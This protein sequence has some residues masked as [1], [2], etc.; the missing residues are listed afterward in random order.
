MQ[1]KKN[2][3]APTYFGQN[4]RY[5]RRKYE[6]SQ[7][8]LA[9]KLDCTR[10]HIASYESGFVEPKALILLKVCAFFGI[11]PEI[12]LSSLLSADPGYL[13]GAGEGDPPAA[14]SND[15]RLYVNLLKNETDAYAKI[16]KGYQVFYDLRKS[17]TGKENL[18]SI[19]NIYEDLL[20][21]MDILL[22][23]NQSFLDDTHTSSERNE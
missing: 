9:E 23:G 8:L 18:Q 13:K 5:L 15:L 2:I 19:Y 21:L 16:V 12:I 3:P 22:E 10:G 14:T 17:Q 4:L 1:K 20:Q 6:M 11:D 7:S